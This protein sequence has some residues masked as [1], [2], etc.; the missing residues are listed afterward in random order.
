MFTD[1]VS[2][3][4]SIISALQLPTVSG[5]VIFA[6][7]EDEAIAIACGL[8]VAG[9][10]PFVSMQNSGLSSSLNT[11][12]SL[13]SAYNIALPLLVAMRGLEG[14]HNA[15]HAPV[16]AATPQLLDALGFWHRPV[17]LRDQ[18]AT[19]LVDCQREAIK[20]RQPT[21][22]LVHLRAISTC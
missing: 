9:R 14:E 13:A 16:G 6:T 10:R 3:P 18:V 19:A 11:L 20:R 22:A 1:H 7:R 17:T 21:F 12:G 8:V 2:V 4:C 5:N 15:T